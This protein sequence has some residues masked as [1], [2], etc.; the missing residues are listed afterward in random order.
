MP[1]IDK[2]DIEKISFLPPEGEDDDVFSA[3][4]D[5][6]P[7]E[8]QT[9]G[10]FIDEGFVCQVPED[11]AKFLIKVD[12]LALGFLA[13]NSEDWLGQEF[14]AQD[15]EARTIPTVRLTEDLKYVWAMTPDPQGVTSFTNDLK[16][17]NKLSWPFFGQAIVV[18]K[19]VKV[20]AELI[21]VQWEVCQTRLLPTNEDP[22]APT[23]PKF[24]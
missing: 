19:G 18:L 20:E 24:E 21:Q 9:Q 12:K 13:A 22:P 10:M 6:D 14:S 3:R 8:I 16:I 23:A 15:L 7:V 5:S 2:I 1:S 11:L 4:L 17:L